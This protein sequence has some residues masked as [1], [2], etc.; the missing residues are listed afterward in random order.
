[1]KKQ[2]YLKS[3]LCLLMM[4]VGIS[5]SWAETVTYTWTY[6]SSKFN[7][8]A[9]GTVPEGSS[10]LL[11]STYSNAN[12]L[13]GKNSQTFTLKGYAGC[14][15]TGVSI[16]MKRSS[17][18]S[19]K[20]NV[21]V[22]ANGAQ[23]G[24]V[25]NQELTTSEVNYSITVNPTQVNSDNDVVITVN[26]AAN[27]IY[28]YNYVITYVPVGKTLL[29]TPAN[30]SS[31]NVTDK[32]ADLSWDA[33]SNASSY[34]VKIGSTEYETTTNSYKA[35]GL[36]AETEHKWSV[37]ALAGTS[38]TYSD[39]VY[40]SEA[41]F[42]TGA[43]V[44]AA[45]EYKVSMN[46]ALYGVSTGSNGTEQSKSKYGVTIVSGCKSGASN[47]TYYDTNHIRY[48]TDSYL[49]LTAPT[50]F[51]I[52]QVVFTANGQWN[53]GPS[54]SEG[55]Y[56]NSS[57]TW[58]GSASQ[59]DFSFSDQNR[60]GSIAVTYEKD[61]EVSVVNPTISY[62]NK[63]SDGV[64]YP[65]SDVTLACATEGATIKYRVD[66]SNG[67]VALE[68]LEQTYSAPFKVS[69]KS[70]YITA[71]AEKDGDKSEETKLTLKKAT[72]YSSLNDLAAATITAGT[73]VVVT[74]DKAT[75]K[76]IF[77]TTQGSYRNGIFFNVQ[78]DGKD[79]ELFCK[80]VPT[81]WVEGGTVSGTVIATW[82]QF[83]GTWE[84]VPTSDW[85]WTNLTYTAPAAPKTTPTLTFTPAKVTAYL[86][87]KDE[88]TAPELTNES[89]VTVTY[90]SSDEKV[91]TVDASG[92]VTLVGAGETTIEAKFAGND[93]YNEAS[94]SYTLIVKA[95]KPVGYAIVAEYN[96]KW[97][98][99]T[100]TISS[101]RLGYVEVTVANGK[102]FYNG[103]SNI[104]WEWDA[105]NGTLTSDEGILS[106]GASTD[107]K[108]NYSGSNTKW[109]ISETEGISNTK[110]TQ[111]ALIFRDTYGFTNYSK[112]S[113]NNSGYSGLAQLL[114]LGTAAEL[115]AIASSVTVGSTGY[116]TY[117]P[118]ANDVTIPSGVEVYY[119]DA[120]GVTDE[121]ISLTKYE[122]TTLK[123]GEGV[124]LK[125]AGTFTF[126]KTTGATAIEGN[127]L[128]GAV[129]DITLKEN[130]SYL[131]AN[132]GG[133]AVLSLC[134]AGTLKAG[135]AYLPASAGSKAPT[136]MLVINDATSI[137]SATYRMQNEGAYNLAG[138]KVGADYKGIVIMNGKKY[139]KK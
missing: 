100:T 10:A 102:A 65:E 111:R 56:S 27:S 67:G 59:I 112:T 15:I 88:F 62:T 36:E 82:T 129:S 41:T 117:C 126:A 121:Y 5:T 81:E 99:A 64:F 122:G 73:G 94:A 105:E 12:Q 80:N 13:T 98:A 130:S 1:M 72:E 30:L 116:A 4:L 47:K 77:T 33:V 66:V 103:E 97:Y 60:I 93:E 119:A 3:L 95:T 68:G 75:I 123:Q 53:N 57:K 90:T 40:S 37:K 76:S 128:K 87:A 114:P 26:A 2:I 45:G 89:K 74:L 28:V 46:N 7:V 38:D 55:T 34:R 58:T 16:K 104:T 29:G 120:A 136:L 113:A 108:V 134:N 86:D 21:T 52:T 23:I 133:N 110:A 11:T 17:S 14:T 109:T 18:T 101:S 106:A 51:K 127:V 63:I 132:E 61:V 71:W 79:I 8:S 31:S 35:T 6:S 22:N 91:A 83:N 70:N 24:S 20:A 9:S 39:G 138:Q 96:G 118:I 115:E 125:T 78:K 107:A 124:I 48:Y 131:L 19:A 85:A 50:G 135:K 54:V 69:A 25:S 84:L 42:T 49:K 92:A 43:F 32:T 139:L 137:E 44:P